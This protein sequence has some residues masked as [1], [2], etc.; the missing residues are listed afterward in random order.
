MLEDKEKIRLY[1]KNALLVKGYSM[2]EA[3]SK[4][5]YGL[6]SFVFSYSNNADN[7]DLIKVEINYLNRV[8]IF[9]P[10]AMKIGIFGYKGTVPINVMNKYEL[11]G[12]KLAALISRCK[13]RDVYDIY[14]MIELGLIEKPETLRKCLIFYNCVGGEADIGDFKFEKLNGLS[15]R[16]YDRIL[17]P[18]LSKNEKFDHKAALSKISLYFE[19]L[20]RFEENELLFISAFKDRRYEPNL[21]FNPR[22]TFSDLNRHPMALWKCS[23]PNN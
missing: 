8:H 7:R 22:D 23:M 17:R 2:S 3:A 20:L 11:F 9:S 5:Y 21:L 6:D 14:R 13:P 4:S 16:D 15:K 1:I 10:N 19:N 12:S 18:M